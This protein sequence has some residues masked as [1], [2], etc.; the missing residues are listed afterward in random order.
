MAISEHAVTLHKPGIAWEE[1]FYFLQSALRKRACQP[2]SAFASGVNTSWDIAGETFQLISNRKWG[3][4]SIR[5][6][7]RAALACAE[8]FTSPII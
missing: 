6:H 3:L 2:R 1:L 8:A 7:F 5:H 4:V